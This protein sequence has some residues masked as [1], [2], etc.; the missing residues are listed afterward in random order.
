ML[1]QVQHDGT[2]N[3]KENDQTE[4]VWANKNRWVL[5]PAAGKQETSLIRLA[6][7]VHFGQPRIRAGVAG[8]APIPARGQGYRTHLGAVRQ[9]RAFELLGEKA[10]EEDLEPLF[11]NSGGKFLFKGLLGQK[12]NFAG[13]KTIPQKVE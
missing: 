10:A 2:Y 1:K 13:A 8:H 9:A 11:N 5:S 3:S 6:Q 4:P 12:I 7:S